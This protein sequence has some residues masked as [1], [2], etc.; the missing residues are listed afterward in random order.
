V[1]I[2]RA[3]V[4]G[5]RILVLDEP[6][7]SL[8]AHDVGRLFDLIRSFKQR[9]LA[10]IYISHF[11][12]EV[13]AVADR[14]VVL[15]DGRTV[16]EGTPTELRVGDIVR[17]MVGREVRDL[18]PRSSRQPGDPLLSVENLAGLTKPSQAS[19]TLHR[20]E[21][22]GI[23]GLMGAGRTEL[24]RCVFGLEPVRSGRIRVGVHAGPRSPVWSWARGI[25]LL[26]EDRKQ[27]GLALQRD[28]ADNITLPRLGGLG[29]RGWIWPQ[30]QASAAARWIDT[31][32][33]VMA[34]SGGNQQKVAL[35]RL[36]HSQVDVLL[37][38]EPTRGIDVAAK[39]ALYRLIDELASSPTPRAVLV[40]SSYVPEL[41]GLCDR[42]AVMCRGRLGP[43][44]PVSDWT[45][46]DLMLAATGQEP[47]PGE[48]DM[49]RQV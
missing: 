29:G 17:L 45:E 13:Q 41:L 6:T 30:R 47:P 48:P 19:L 21:V 37:L 4:A 2:A 24:L 5:C 46:H 33:P 39:A 11:L 43:A 12:E 28:V 22:L 27:E 3:L 10:V 36:L 9:G 15:R 25:G 40:V 7:S 26:S 31:R 35:A 44:R 20:G 32:Q 42:I 14:I 49:R 34:L 1:E 18:Y 23:A 16:G 38:D 8:T